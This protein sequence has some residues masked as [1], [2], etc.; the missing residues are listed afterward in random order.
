MRLATA[1]PCRGG[2]SAEPHARIHGR[3]EEVD[4]QVEGDEDEGE[5]EHARQITGKSRPG[6]ACTMRRPSPGHAKTVSM[7]MAPSA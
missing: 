2:A 7:M 4:D 3:V 5:D 6:T 1:A